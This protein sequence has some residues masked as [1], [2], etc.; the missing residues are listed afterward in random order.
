MGYY[1]DAKN[2]ETYVEMADGY[3][4]PALIEV[5]ATML[6]PGSTVLELGMGPGKDFALLSQRYQVTGSDN[7]AL[8]VSDTASRIRMP[9]W[10][11][12]TP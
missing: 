8:F 10:C 6:E 12:L 11:S 2:V 9:I 4:G 5:L 1:D 3:D 7:S